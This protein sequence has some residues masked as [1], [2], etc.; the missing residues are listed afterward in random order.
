RASP[1][2]GKGIEKP[3][4][5]LAFGKDLTIE[6]ECAGMAF[7]SQFAATRDYLAQRANRV[8]PKSRPQ[9]YNNR[10]RNGSPQQ[11]IRDHSP[12]LLEGELSLFAPLSSP[13]DQPEQAKECEQKEGW[14]FGQP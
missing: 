1:Q 12:K 7:R 4:G 13:F 6:E 11:R 9:Q 5:V 3:A 8:Y 10:S 2:I 14:C